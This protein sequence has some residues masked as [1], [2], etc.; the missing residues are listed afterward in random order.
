MDEA[1][2]LCTNKRAVFAK[3]VPGAVGEGEGKRNWPRLRLSEPEFH[4][5]DPES[6][7]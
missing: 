1:T 2:H 6:A 5:Q 4:G 7:L 3:E